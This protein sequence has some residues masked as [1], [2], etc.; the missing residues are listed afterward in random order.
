MGEKKLTLPDDIEFEGSKFNVPSKAT[1]VPLDHGMG[2]CSTKLFAD[3]LFGLNKRKWSGKVLVGFE[4]KKEEKNIYFHNG[5]I[6]FATSNLIDDR[7]GEVSYRYG[8]ITLDDLFD[9]SVQVERNAKIGQL[10]TKNKI[11][12]SVDLWDAL[13]IQVAEILKSTM[14][15]PSVYFEASPGIKPP[16]MVVFDDCTEDL[17]D[18]AFS[19]G[20]MYMEFVEGIDTEA[21]V[22]LLVDVDEVVQESSFD[23]EV[24][25]MVESSNSLGEYLKQ[26]RLAEHNSYLALLNMI[27]YGFCAMLPPSISQKTSTENSKKMGQ[28]IEKYQH[29]LDLVNKSYEKDNVVLPNHELKKFASSLNNRTFLSI[30]LNNNGGIALSSASCMLSQCRFSDRQTVYFQRKIEALTYFLL[31]I[32]RD[33]LSKATYIELQKHLKNSKIV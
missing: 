6:I 32:A 4:E 1:N 25:K 24:L 26:S 2:R 31:N 7:M 13:K 30:F 5:E 14:L 19:F 15:A 21:E 17:L 18:H 28:T 16:C 22:K 3:F 20:C 33:G 12:S 8:Y 9:T 27:H 11:F 10:L 29:A 23:S